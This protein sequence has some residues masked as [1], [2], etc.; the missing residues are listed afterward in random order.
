M[1]DG[2]TSSDFKDIIFVLNY[3]NTVWDELTAAD[4]IV[5]PYLK[6][7]FRKLLAGK[8]INEWIAVHPDYTD[9]QRGDLILGRLKEFVRNQTN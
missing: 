6:D 7:E 1:N 4:K 3:R 2:R 5:K 9:R 8:Y